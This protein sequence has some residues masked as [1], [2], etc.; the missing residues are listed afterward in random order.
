MGYMCEDFPGTEDK[1]I[2]FAHGLWVEEKNILLKKFLPKG[3]YAHF[4]E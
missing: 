3:L 4:S 1:L 2:L